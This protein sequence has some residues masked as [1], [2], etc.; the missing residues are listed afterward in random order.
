MN[1]EFADIKTWDDVQRMATEDVTRYIRWDAA[2][3]QV[4]L[5]SQQ[6][7][8]AQIRQQQEERA[9]F[10]KFAE[11]ESAKFLELVPEMADETKAAELQKAAVSTLK[12]A[13]FAEG[14][15]ADAW[16]GKAHVPFRDARVQLM[17]HKAALWDQAQAKAKTVAAKPVP[18]VQRPVQ[19]PG[20]VQPKGEAQKARAN[21]LMTAIDGKH[22]MGAIRAAAEAL[23]ARRAASR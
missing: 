1:G 20:T 5:V 6:V 17:I 16:Q 8:A 4:A 2:Q 23:K 19:R 13:G 12:A 10:A 14:E 9:Q 15:L 3:K 21:N 7:S 11:T 22:G 18:P